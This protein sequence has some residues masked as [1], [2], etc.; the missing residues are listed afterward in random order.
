MH[1]L[2]S[3]VFQEFSSVYYKIYQ[4]YAYANRKKLL[5]SQLV[6]LQSLAVSKFYGRGQVL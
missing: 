5:A 4:Q 1:D 2:P 6:Q 3:S